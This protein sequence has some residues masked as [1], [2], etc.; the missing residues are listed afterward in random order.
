MLA[1]YGICERRP[2]APAATQGRPRMTD[3]HKQ[4]DD[5]R[6]DP[7]PG[8]RK[9]R[10]AGGHS[11]SGVDGIAG[12]GGSSGT[13]SVRTDVPDRLGDV[14]GITPDDVDVPPPG[15]QGKH[16][17]GTRDMQSND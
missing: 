5:E 7:M 14:S 6:D 9:D 15:T 11:N 8:G 3:K 2:M 12:T 1:W 10:G 17:G 16:P 4:R 13:G